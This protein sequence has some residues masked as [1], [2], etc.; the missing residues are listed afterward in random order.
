MLEEKW[1]D[2]LKENNRLKAEIK[3]CNGLYK[4]LLQSNMEIGLLCKRQSKEIE[5]LK[6]KPQIGDL[7]YYIGNADC[8]ECKYSESKSYA[9]CTV[10]EDEHIDCL[11]VVKERKFNSSD[12]YF[13]T[14][15]E[16]ELALKDGCFQNGKHHN[17]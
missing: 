13:V 9:S 2:T 12:I 4:K 6:S 3:Q 17:V 16:A 7:I 11:V 1:I 8:M 10:M 5:Q 14:R 15:E